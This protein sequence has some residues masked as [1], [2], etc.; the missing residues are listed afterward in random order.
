MGVSRSVNNILVLE[1]SRRFSRRSPCNFTCIFRCRWVAVYYR[2]ILLRLLL[3]SLFIMNGIV[4]SSGWMLFC[5]CLRRDLGVWLGESISVVFGRI[6]HILEVLSFGLSQIVHSLIVRQSWWLILLHHHLVWLE[7]VLVLNVWYHDQSFS[8]LLLVRIN[9]H[10]VGFV[11][12][13][14]VVA[15]VDKTKGPYRR[16]GFGSGFSYVHSLSAFRWVN[17]VGISREVLFRSSVWLTF[18][19]ALMSVVP[20][21][22]LIT[23]PWP[24]LLQ[25][26]VL[27][28]DKRRWLS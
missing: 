28:I 23:S 11:S 4:E 19:F 2:A 1:L 9:K 21:R 12:V 13:R 26:L 10:L 6:E 25:L 18:E 14:L 16:S 17:G 24:L 3:D 8:L 5:M 20:D 22:K 15:V 7:L 27:G